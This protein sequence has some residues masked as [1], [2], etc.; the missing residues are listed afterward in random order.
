[1]TKETWHVLQ[2]QRRR[3]SL[4]GKR[5]LHSCFRD[6]PWRLTSGWWR[7]SKVV[8]FKLWNSPYFQSSQKLWNIFSFRVNI[9]VDTVAFEM[10]TKLLNVVQCSGLR[11]R[12]EESQKGIEVDVFINVKQQ[13]QQQLFLLNDRKLWGKNKS[14][15]R[16]I[17]QLKIHKFRD[18][19]MKLTSSRTFQ[20]HLESPPLTPSKA[21]LWVCTVSLP[22]Q[23]IQSEEDLR[24]E[25]ILYRGSPSS[26]MG[27]LPPKT[28]QSNTV[29]T[30]EVGTSREMRWPNPNRKLV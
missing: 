13:Q 23:N 7:G 12:L 15:H 8:N 30:E 11:Q 27:W 1:M 16:N 24:H 6:R 25:C 28:I 20:L 5:S 4:T 26:N 21:T 22:F 3:R 14:K 2:V 9:S 18:G 29:H 17:E 10:V 19:Q